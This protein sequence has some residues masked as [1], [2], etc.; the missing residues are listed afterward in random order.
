LAAISKGEGS[1][2]VPGSSKEEGGQGAML[3]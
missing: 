2:T 1:S 3:P